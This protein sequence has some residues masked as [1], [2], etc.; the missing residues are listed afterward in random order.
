MHPLPPNPNYYRPKGKTIMIELIGICLLYSAAPIIA[1]VY[2]L[3]QFERNRRRESD[4]RDSVRQPWFARLLPKIEMRDKKADWANAHIFSSFFDTDINKPPFNQ[5]R[6]GEL[7]SKWNPKQ[8]TEDK[9]VDTINQNTQPLRDDYSS[10]IDKWRLN[11]EPRPDLQAAEF[12]DIGNYTRA[13]QL[14]HIQAEI[15]AHN[16]L[17]GAAAIAFQRASEAYEKILISGKEHYPYNGKYSETAIDSGTAGR[18]LRLAQ[19]RLAS[20]VQKYKAHGDLERASELSLRLRRMEGRL[21]SWLYRNIF[22]KGLGYGEDPLAVLLT[23][24][25]AIVLFGLI[26]SLLIHFNCGGLTGS[27]DN[28]TKQSGWNALLPTT[29]YFSVVTATTVG[30]GDL[31]PVGVFRLLSGAEAIGGIIL[32]SLFT[33]VLVRRLIG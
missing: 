16:N 3:R 33:V 30:Y 20:A 13:A 12:D 28:L 26:Y 25:N 9:V 23:F 31:A 29:L 21:H 15:A 5:T 27:G 22:G 4:L 10:F 24:F 2:H 8:P 19:M 11:S 7:R 32:I 17:D 6:L 1:V 14:F 18:Y